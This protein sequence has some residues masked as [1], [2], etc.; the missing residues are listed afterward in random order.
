MALLPVTT[1]AAVRAYKGL[2]IAGGAS[3][4]WITSAIAAFSRRFEA[5]LGRALLEEVQTEVLDVDFDGQTVFPLKGWPVLSSPA[6]SVRLDALRVFDAATELEATF[7]TVDEEE[8]FL[9]VDGIVLPRG[10]R[11]LRVVYT[12]GMAADEAAF[13]AAYPDAAEAADI[14]I[15]YWF[16]SR[17]R[18][19]QKS[20]VGPDNT[21]TMESTTEFL[22]VVNE[23]I[24][25]YRRKRW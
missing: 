17:L 15:N 9:I 18:L 1:I 21:V 10:M 13:L 5:A 20:V 11:V 7:Y 14:Q 23:A 12:G 8:G 24:A 22:P 6:I 4:A 16:E 25:R 3:D 2:A 19:G